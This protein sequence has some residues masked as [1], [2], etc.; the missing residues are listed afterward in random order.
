M[1]ALGF[2]RFAACEPFFNQPG[3]LNATYGL[4]AAG[5]AG[6]QSHV[7]DSVS[8]GSESAARATDARESLPELA[9]DAEGEEA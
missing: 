7:P 1:R 3:A 2:Y 5:S 6:T 8:F 9:Q 4:L